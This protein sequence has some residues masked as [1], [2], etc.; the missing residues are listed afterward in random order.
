MFAIDSPAFRRA[1]APF[2]PSVWGSIAPAV[3]TE[4]AGKQ[5]RIEQ[6]CR[7]LSQQQSW[8]RLRSE[9]GPILRR[10]RDIKDCLARSGAAHRVADIGCSR[11]RFLTAVTHC[12]AMRARFTSID[13]A[14]TLGV[15]PDAA[16]EIVDELL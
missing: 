13:L 7:F 3:Q 2:D 8:N 16:A 15:L 10:P 14:W 5:E 1:G 4:H 6:A 11:E 9:L 12:G